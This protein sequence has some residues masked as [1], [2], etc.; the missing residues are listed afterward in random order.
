MGATVKK[1]LHPERTPDCGNEHSDTT[2]TCSPDTWAL[3]AC[4]DVQTLVHAHRTYFL[5]AACWRSNL[6][7]VEMRWRFSGIFSS[8]FLRLRLS[9]TMNETQTT[10]KRVRFNEINSCAFHH[11]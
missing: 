8:C 10:R 9:T 5:R 11:T 2:L 4:R 1:P 7:T 6:L 3:S